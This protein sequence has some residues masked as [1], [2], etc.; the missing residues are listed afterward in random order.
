MSSSNEQAKDESIDGSSVTAEVEAVER[1]AGSSPS[2]TPT[3]A[4]TLAPAPTPVPVPAPS[5]ESA[6]H[7]VKLSYHDSG[8]DIR[9][10]LLH[11]T[12]TTNKKVLF[13]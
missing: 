11:V 8:I 3:P 12:P 6:Q 9:D 1:G 10:P 2:P 7:L 5:A 13:V 4:P